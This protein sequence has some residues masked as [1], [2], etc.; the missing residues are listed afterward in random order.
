MP[1]L[2]GYSVGYLYMHH[3][4]Q[5]LSASPAY[6]NALTRSPTLD[7]A[8]G[9]SI[10]LVV[11]AHS[12]LAQLLPETNQTIALFRMPFFFFLAG[13][14]LPSSG[15]LSGFAKKKTD[16]LLKPYAVTVIAV[17]L[18]PPLARGESL[19]VHWVGGIYG[20]GQSLIWTPLWFLTHLWIASLL[21]FLY[22]TVLKVILKNNIERSSITI[23]ISTLLLLLLCAPYLLEAAGE[24]GW[25]WSIDLLPISLFFIILGRT[26]STQTKAFKPSK[27]IV[28]AA[29]IGIILAKYQGAFV[30]LNYRE[31]SPVIWSAVAALCGTYCLLA[32]AFTLNHQADKPSK[33]H[34]FISLPLVFLSIF[35]QRVRSLLSLMGRNSLY[36]LLFHSLMLYYAR[37]LLESLGLSDVQALFHA[38]SI[39][40]AIAFCLMIKA[41][42]QAFTVS[43]WLYFPK[44]TASNCYPIQYLENWLWGLVKRLL[45]H[46]RQT[47]VVRR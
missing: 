12:G 30:S 24:K 39:V 46:C 26:V 23:T 33:Q 11:F 45:G 6:S 16:T 9:I 2:T 31:Y 44:G 1:I 5:I 22:F 41:G 38:L 15:N 37:N 34:S 28:L 19:W 43:R 13:V 36:I 47:T 14:C 42:L 29:L 35:A 8:R 40:M 4:N 3:T 7:I 18:L 17:S 21:A 25:P 10:L 32:L 20:T 27:K